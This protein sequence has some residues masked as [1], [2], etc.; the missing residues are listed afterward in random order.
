M[1][2]GLNMQL[3][4]EIT[5]AWMLCKPIRYGHNFSSCSFSIEEGWFQRLEKERD[6]KGFGLEMKFS[7]MIIESRVL[8]LDVL[9]IYTHT[10]IAIFYYPVL[11]LTEI[12]VFCF[13]FTALEAKT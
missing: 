6:R 3:C 4:E 2:D 12:T 7:L 8:I 1:N 5:A 9:F 10:A 13:F 11:C